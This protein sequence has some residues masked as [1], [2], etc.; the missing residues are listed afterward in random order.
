VRLVDDQ[1]VVLL[2]RRV[3]LDLGQQDAV[4]HQLDQ[5][6]V[7]GTIGEPDLPADRTADRDA[8]FL[9]DALGHRARCQPARLRVPDGAADPATQLQ[10]DLGKL[11]GLAGPGLPR[12]DH[13]LM[14]TDRLGDLADVPADR[15][16]RRVMNPRCGSLP[17]R[18][19]GLGQRCA[20]KQRS[21]RR[22]KC[23]QPRGRRAPGSPASRS[24]TLEQ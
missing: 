24:P 8:E 7:A 21:P 5:S 23:R 3:G 18:D 20:H 2:Q 22:A 6:V 14:G 17:A 4:G 19:F 11:G 10:A 12:D 9:G 16:R 13:H 1:R 15:Q